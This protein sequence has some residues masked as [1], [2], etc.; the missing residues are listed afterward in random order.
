LI[1]GAAA[2][3]PKLAFKLVGELGIKST[4]QAISRIVKAAKTAEERTATLAALRGHLATLADE[5][6]RMEI[7]RDAMTTFAR[8]MVGQQSFEAAS[9]W[10]AAAKLAPEELQSFA[11]G[12]SHDTTAREQGQWIEWVGQTLPAGKSDVS[13]YNL[14]RKWTQDDYQAAGKWLAATPAGPTKNTAIRSYA[15]IVSKYDSATATQ[16]AMTLPPGKKREETLKNIQ[17]NSPTK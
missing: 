5:K 14:V 9:Q 3:D 7:A 11:D 17:E 13:I 8:E 1:S 10:L 16:W 12:M 2:S 15:E 6:N 4:S